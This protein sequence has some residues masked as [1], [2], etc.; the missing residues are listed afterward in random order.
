MEMVARIVADPIYSVSR[1]QKQSS[2]PASKDRMIWMFGKRNSTELVLG[3]ESDNIFVIR[4]REKTKNQ[5]IGNITEADE[6][7]KD[8]L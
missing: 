8:D 6:S 2:S 7:A 3:S 4:A 1:L 5:E